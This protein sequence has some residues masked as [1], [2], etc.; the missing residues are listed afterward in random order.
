MT[1]KL[2]KKYSLMSR[3]PSRYMHCYSVF[4]LPAIT[5]SCLSRVHNINLLIL[6]EILANKPCVWLFIYLQFRFT[7]G[8]LLY[9]CNEKCCINL[10]Q[11]IK[12]NLC[13]ILIHL[14]SEYHS[15]VCLQSWVAVFKPN[16]SAL[17]SH[18]FFW[19]F[20]S[21]GSKSNNLKMFQ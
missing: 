20:M 17:C 7:V 15:T 21:T 19:I 2:H 4:S 11:S 10:V 14:R 8:K 6:Q 12:F 9:H 3:S 13:H 16:L 1:C 18:H 5:P